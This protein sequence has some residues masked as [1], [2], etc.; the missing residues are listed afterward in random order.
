MLLS[1]VLQ[2]GSDKVSPI[3]IGPSKNPRCFKKLKKLPGDIMYY[4]QKNS[5]IDN[6]IFKD[7]MLHLDR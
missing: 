2:S 7:Y 4:N 5:W 3:V 1:V 6:V